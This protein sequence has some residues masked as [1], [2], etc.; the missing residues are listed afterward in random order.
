MSSYKEDIRKM[1]T[2]KSTLNLYELIE[3]LIELYGSYNDNK[4]KYL[5]TDSIEDM[6]NM[7]LTKDG[8]LA[9]CFVMNTPE[10]KGKLNW[11]YNINEGEGYLTT[12]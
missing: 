12:I 6:L 11:H 10:A 8:R 4:E 5:S 9:A 1:C 3:I 2:Y 7:I